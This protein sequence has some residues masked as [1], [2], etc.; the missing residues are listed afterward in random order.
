[1]TQNA[2]EIAHFGRQKK[3]GGYEIK[4]FR[5]AI[6]REGARLPAA[7]SP[8]RRTSSP[9]GGSSAVPGGGRLLVVRDVVREYVRKCAKRGDFCKIAALSCRNRA[10][11]R[12]GGRVLVTAGFN[13]FQNGNSSFAKCEGIRKR[14]AAPL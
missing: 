1:M 4:D 3:G 5:R 11:S 2:V 10:G 12:E 13:C 9:F 6:K 7:K 8:R 14:T